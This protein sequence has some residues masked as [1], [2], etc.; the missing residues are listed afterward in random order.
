MK[1][2]KTLLAASLAVA[3]VAAHAQDA[4]PVQV[5]ENLISTNPIYGDIFVPGTD[6]GFVQAP[7]HGQHA[8]AT[9]PVGYANNYLP[10]I[11]ERKWVD[12]RVFAIDLGTGAVTDNNTTGQDVKYD[13][14]KYKGAANEIVYEFVDPKTEVSSGYFVK[15]S[16]GNLVAYTGE[17]DVNTL[18][19][20]GQIAGTTGGTHSTGY[21]NR[22]VN[23]EHVLYGYQGSTINQAGSVNG[24]IVNPD[25]SEERVQGNLGASVSKPTDIR[26]VQNGILA[27]TGRGPYLDPSKNIYGVSARDNNN[28]TMMTGNGVALADLSN[29]GKLQTDGS[30]ITNDKLINTVAS[31]TQKTREYDVGGK[32]ILEIYNNDKGRELESKYYEITANGTDLA[33]W[34][35]V[36]PTAGTHVKT[37]TAN[38]NEGTYEVAKTH[39]TVTNK[40]V[41]YSES[42][43]TIDKT[44]VNAGITTPGGN[45]TDIKSEFGA[46]AATVKTE[47]A[48]ST[49]VIGTNEDKSNKYGL[50]VSKTDANGT[51]KTTI[52]SGGISTTGVI[53]A[54]DYQIG[55][56]SIVE[57][58]NTTVEGAVA[59]ATEAIDKKVAEVD[60]KIVE[61]DARLTQFN[62]TATE[63]NGRVDQLNNRIDDVEKTS[64]RGIAIAL[65]AQQAIPNL[66]A[67]QTAVFGGAGMYKSEGAGALG[68][69]TVLADGRTSFSG[70]L[71]V[72]G[73]GEVGGRVGVAY[74]FGGK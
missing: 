54:K 66:S 12:G 57:N 3:A 46:G 35:G 44:V 59:G 9:N 14:F 73:G 41:T 60:T 5:T 30:V 65:A 63:L 8:S 4:R 2:Q 1:F 18:E 17:V 31:G 71:G 61:V 69:A 34:K 53:N 32:R 28:V 19:K 27:N 42:I 7:A 29:G 56:V 16:A 13:V 39:N 6:I 45:T 72:A 40:N 67:G 22:V 25:G 26:Y 10:E 37:G 11:K 58:I 51:E 21:E 24:T 15:N 62:A 55:G 49:G 74:V 48:V 20:G 47:Q 23:G 43:S 36:T 70:A 33:E 68:V 50:E 52:T 38:Y 64:Y